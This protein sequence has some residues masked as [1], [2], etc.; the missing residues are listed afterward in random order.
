MSSLFGS[1]YTAVTGLTAQSS[2]IGNISDNLSN[3]STTGYKT[4]GTNFEE[5]VSQTTSKVDGN[6]IGTQT[7][8]VYYNNL[9]GSLATVNSQTYIAVSGQG[10]FPVT[11][12]TTGT[13]VL[14]TRSGDFDLNADGFLQN[15]EGYNLMGW[16]YDQTNQTVD[17]NTLVPISVSQLT[18]SSVT[19]QNLSYDANIPASVAN[20]TTLPDQPV[21]I[22]DTSGGAHVV[23]YSW[24]KTG[25]NTWDLTVKAAG[26]ASTGTT[27]GDYSG[28][29]HFT[30]DET[31]HIAAIDSTDMTGTVTPANPATSTPASMTLGFNLSYLTKA[32]PTST[33]TATTQSITSAMTSMTQFADK[34]AIL[35]SF[36]QDGASAGSF[37][38][39]SINE[40]GI[41]SVNYDNGVTK[42][43]YEIPLTT[44]IS[45]GNLLRTSGN[46]YRATPEAGTAMYKASGTG[47]AG[48]ISVGSLEDST[49]DIAG[50]FTLMIQAQQAYSANAKVITAAD[51]M[52]QTLI[53]V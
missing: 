44:F 31:G 15:S 18:T 8:P 14:Y 16:A 2:C 42:A 22:Y 53:T 32:T 46:A 13:E 39:I 10:F 12:E 48:S 33:P 25:T 11:S 34:S 43:I 24:T 38:G 5:M 45:P 6:G 49:V 47:G 19:T 4:I 23:N 9:Q 27:S 52:L 21:T 36:T 40:G 20:G 29:A 7:R 30:F 17:Q 50:Q 41:V 1:I 35:S 28:V 37:S 26:G 51:T 3:S